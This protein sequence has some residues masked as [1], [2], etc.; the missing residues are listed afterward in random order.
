MQT[1][2]NPRHV[3]KPTYHDS[4]KKKTSGY[5]FAGKAKTAYKKKN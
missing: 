1:A 2:G 4:K 3:R 5:V